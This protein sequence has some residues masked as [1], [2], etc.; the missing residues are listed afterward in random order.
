MKLIAM[1]KEVD[2]KKFGLCKSTNPNYVQLLMDVGNWRKENPNEKFPKP[3]SFASL[4]PR[5]QSFTTDI[6]RYCY[7]SAIG[8]FDKKKDG[9]LENSS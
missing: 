4:F 2:E 1:S 8:T 7:N 9:E 5:W 6:F 3:Q